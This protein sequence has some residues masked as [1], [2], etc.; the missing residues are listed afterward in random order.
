MLAAAT[1]D[2]RTKLR[3]ELITPRWGAGASLPV[4]VPE[5]APDAAEQASGRLPATLRIASA[6]HRSDLR[7]VLAEE[8][9]DD[10]EQ[11][12]APAR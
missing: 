8:G 5:F 9:E 6:Q 7:I 3:A 11:R 10:P 1:H 2:N 12:R 4:I